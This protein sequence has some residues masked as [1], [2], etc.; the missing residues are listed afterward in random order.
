MKNQRQRIL[1]ATMVGT[2]ALGA[3]NST[4]PSWAFD[5][6]GQMKEVGTSVKTGATEVV[7]RQL[8]EAKNKAKAELQAQLEKEMRAQLEKGFKALDEEFDKKI[9]NQKG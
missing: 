9:K 2:L 4:E 3:W 8:E 7:I 6:L 5:P 1:L